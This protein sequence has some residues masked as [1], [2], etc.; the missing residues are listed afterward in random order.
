MCRCVGT[1]TVSTLECVMLSSLTALPR[2]GSFEEQALAY[3]VRKRWQQGFNIGVLP[4]HLPGTVP[5]EG[6][7]S[8]SEEE[9]RG[10]QRSE[11]K[12]NE[13]K[14]RG[15]V[16]RRRV[17]RREVK[18][19]GERG[20]DEGRERRRVERR[21]MKRRGE[22]RRKRKRAKRGEKRGHFSFLYF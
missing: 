6:E 9:R 21:G 17:K 15:G 3:C 5:T 20:G 13:V 11:G 7:E 12:Q 2:R 8:R 4:N 1:E 14:R 22:G 10:E 19:R 16:K 18:R